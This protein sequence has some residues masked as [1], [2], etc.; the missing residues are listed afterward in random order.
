MNK[1]ARVLITVA[2]C[3]I[4]Y[5]IAFVYFEN[6]MLLIDK[7]IHYR[8]LSYFV[9]FS[10]IGIPVFAGTFFVNDDHKIAKNL[11]LGGNVLR[12]L[13]IA[14]IFSLPMFIGGLIFN[15]L[16]PHILIPNLIAK[17]ICAAF[18]E[19]LYFRGFLFGQVFKNTKAGFI[20]SI[21]VCAVLFGLGHMYQ[22]RDVSV[23]IGIFLTTF[24]GAIFFAWLFVE[25]NFNLWVPIFL[26]TFMNLSWGI[27]IVSD[28][29]LGTVN[30]NI[31]RG[32][33][34]AVAII[35][36]LLYKKRKGLKLAV[37]RETVWIKN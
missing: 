5:S 31:F 17:T 20:P 22:S 37:N 30:S 18:F 23:L 4:A 26:H 27:F 9:T 29:A 35:V 3:F 12:A 6:I 34:I 1:T 10:L 2:L 7:V 8:L 21:L 24:S 36:T 19:E 28:N 32:I 25:W 33:T 16:N 13:L 14:A 15:R 11:G